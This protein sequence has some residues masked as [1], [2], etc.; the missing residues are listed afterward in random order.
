MAKLVGQYLPE[1]LDRLVPAQLAASPIASGS[2]TWPVLDW[3][4]MELPW[5][6]S[7]VAPGLGMGTGREGCRLPS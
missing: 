2:W 1:V 7:E 5:G 6:A 3:L 4:S